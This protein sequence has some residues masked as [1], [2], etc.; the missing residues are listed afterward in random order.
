MPCTW[1]HLKIKL[2][3]EFGMTDGGVRTI[4]A[5]LFSMADGYSDLSG[6]EV[7]EALLDYGLFSEKIPPCFQSVGL[8]SYLQS[9]Q[10]PNPTQY[11]FKS[12]SYI[13]YRM[14][15]NVSIPRMLSIPHPQAYA[16]LSY[17][18]EQTWN[19]VKKHMDK[20]P[21]PKFG[22]CHVRKFYDK[23]FI[24][25]MNYSPDWSKENRTV[26]Y[27]LGCQFVVT[28]DIA[29]FYPSL[30]SH[31]IPWAIHEKENAKNDRKT[32]YSVKDFLQ[33]PDCWANALDLVIRHTKD[34]ETNGILI[35]P[36]SSS[37]ISEIILTA[38][39]TALKKENFSNVIRHIDDYLYF[40]KDK[41]DADRFLHSLELNLRKFELSLNAKKTK[42]ESFEEYQLHS[43]ESWTAKLT[44]F[45]WPT[46]NEKI[47]YSSVSNFLSLALELAIENNNNAIISYAF[48][49]IANRENLSDRAKILYARN[50]LQLSLQYPY[51]LSFLQQYV[52]SCCGEEI[53]KILKDY[54]PLLLA[55]GVTTANTDALSYVFFFAVHYGVQIPVAEKVLVENIE[56]LIKMN[57]CIPLVLA[58]EYV[59]HFNIDT[60]RVKITE[61]VDD[62]QK[63]ASERM[64]D[65]FWLLIYNVL[66]K[67]KITDE[68]LL[69]LKQLGFSF[70]DWGN[71]AT[72]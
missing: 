65:K 18:L 24:Y 30:Y 7:Y 28:T 22:Y 40:A 17:V 23:P 55:R 60:G 20:Q 32:P 46:T 21:V 37:I 43:V 12:H 27:S 64:Q 9:K 42:I 68:F 8:Y 35:G 50:A 54:L 59:T 33:H 52:F 72:C 16:Q 62:I 14:S 10:W 39:D 45:Q 51:L 53:K 48:K 47:G 19:R 2:L 41:N 29:N 11:E 57:D 15:R 70:I 63:S 1:C 71:S 67:D 5:I 13:T 66:P 26:E 69:D 25:Q 61:F 58:F 4:H 6:Q 44:Q 36:H 49:I 38:V 34:N 56:E 3:K 31:S